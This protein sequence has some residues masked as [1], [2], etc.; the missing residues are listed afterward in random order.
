[1]KHYDFPRAAD[2]FAD[3]MAFT[4]GSH[5]L[6]LLVNSRASRDRYQ[7]VDVRYPNDYAA[8]HVPGAINLPKGKWRNPQGLNKNATLY[9][10]CYNPT[11]HLAAEAAVEL[12]SQGYRVVEVEGGW[13]TWV[14]NGYGIEVTAKS[15]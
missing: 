15:A 11:C 8:G 6:E 10:Y 12:V 7:V 1:M 13:D 3:K 5:E 4:T 9:L 14:K 2:Y